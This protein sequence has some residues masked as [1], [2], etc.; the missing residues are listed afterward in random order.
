[1][2]LSEARKIKEQ[3]I[4][5]EGKRNNEDAPLIWKTMFYPEGMLDFVKQGCIVN[6]NFDEIFAKSYQFANYHICVLC[7]SYDNQITVEN[8]ETFA[9]KQIET[10]THECVFCVK[11]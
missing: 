2:N 4:Q 9:N 8:F 10:E 6:F 11:Y 1:M 5:F 3:L 7:K